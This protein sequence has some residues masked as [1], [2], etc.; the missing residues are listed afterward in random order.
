MAVDVVAGSS[1]RQLSVPDPSSPTLLEFYATT[2]VTCNEMMPS[3]TAVHEQFGTEAQM[4]AV[5]NERYK[6]DASL[7]SDW[8]SKGGEWPLARDTETATLA[9]RYDGIVT[10]TFVVVDSAGREQWRHQGFARTEEL[11]TGVESGLE[12]AE[13]SRQ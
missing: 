9:T 2:C 8:A 7:Q 3:V 11:L 4:L 6:D 13:S 12:Q 10:P 5:T 1:A